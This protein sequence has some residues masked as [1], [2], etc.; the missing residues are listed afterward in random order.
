M[1]TTAMTTIAT[2][3][4]TTVTVTG[5]H[6][7]AM[8]R[9]TAVLLT[10]L[11]FLTGC[12]KNAQPAGGEQEK[13]SI[14]CATFPLYDWVR[15]IIG[16][17]TDRFEVTLLM[18]NLVDLH[19]Y[20]PSVSDIVKIGAADLF[21]HVGGH[22]DGWVEDVLRTAANP[23]MIVLNSVE[24]L[25]DSVV[26]EV[27]IEGAEHI[28][29]DD[30]DD[31]H[32]SGDIKLNEDEH[33]W[34]SLRHAANLVFV[35]GHAID[36][37]D[38]GNASS[39]YSDN[40]IAYR[41]RLLDLNMEYQEMADAADINTLVFADRFPFR[42]MMDDYGLNFYAAF[43]GCSAASEASFSTIV[44]LATKVE[45][46]GLNSVMVTESGNHA[47]A[48]TVIDSTP[49]RDQQILVLNA[50]QSV[51]RSDIDNGMTY[52][53]VMESNLDVLRGALS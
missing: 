12:A 11:V 33:V 47:I 24:L 46:L 30:C 40:A 28:C 3:T 42:Y 52:L 5:T 49:S 4:T 2:M 26:M 27:E 43:S 29:D 53:S 13:L 39:V 36:F 20:Q 50:M 16:E 22:S 7:K 48:R 37:L 44:F 45:E 35:I 1:T 14:V 41:H 10:V 15:E 21:I 9:L 38:S 31:D 6:I 25:G 17:N 32:S 19:S 23:D 51:L 34:L 18:D 8:K